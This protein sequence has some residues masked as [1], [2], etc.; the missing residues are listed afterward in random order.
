VSDSA[1]SPASGACQS[2]GVAETTQGQGTPEELG[3]YARAWLADNAADYRAGVTTREADVPAQ[4]DFV[5]RM[6]EAGLIAVSWPTDARGRGLSDAHEA[7]VLSALADYDLPIGAFGIAL[8]TAGPTIMQLGTSAQRAELGPRIVG[9]DDIWC[10]LFSEPG[11]GSDLAGLRTSAVRVDGGWRVDGRK[12]WTTSA[13]R[14]DRAVLLARTDPSRPKHQGITMFMIDMHADGVT[15]QPLRDMS[16]RIEFNEVLL[17]SVFVPE[18]SVLGEVDGGWGVANAMLGHERNS[19]ASGLGRR[20]STIA[21]T[22]F[23]VV[24]DRALGAGLVDDTARAGLRELFV[25]ER[26]GA[27]LRSRFSEETDAGIDI[28]A[29]A[30]IAKVH[31]GENDIRAARIAAQVLSDAAAFAADG[32]DELLHQTILAAPSLA[33]AGGTN[34]VQRSIIGERLLGLPREPDPQRGAAFQ[35]LRITG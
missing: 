11:A 14:A 27:T 22:S 25:G 7:A 19:I 32:G 9:G 34:E 31:L 29:R 20:D 10:Q 12:I 3:A 30:S 1:T 15:V 5:R 28:G 35:D 13:H 16:G 4:R 8:G 21:A 6:G 17:E 18:G 23:D 26:I 33:I 24:R 2:E